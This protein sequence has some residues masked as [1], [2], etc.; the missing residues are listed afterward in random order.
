MGELVELTRQR[1]VG[2]WGHSGQ[3]EEHGQKP[4]DRGKMV[5][6]DP[7]EGL[8]VASA[9]RTSGV[10][11]QQAWRGRQGLEAECWGSS[12]MM[13]PLNRGTLVRKGGKGLWEGGGGQV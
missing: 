4:C 12:E 13:A 10:F 2:S 1:R 3:R 6:Q 8:C 9:Q 5:N 7:Q 11:S